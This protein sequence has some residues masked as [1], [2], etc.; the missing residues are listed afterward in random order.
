MI[1]QTVNESEFIQCL[2][3]DEYA[4]WSYNGAQALF[5]YLE[6]LSED[7]GEDIEL[8]RVA[9]R[10]DYSQYSSAWEAM[11]QYQP[12][13]MPTVDDEP[14]ENGVGLDLVELGAAQ[15]QAAFEWLEKR[16]TV[17]QFEGGVIIAQF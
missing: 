12:E 1:K 14:D 8:D 3:S 4:N 13:D 2:L 9:L 10:C 11:D 7:I 16:T 17:I 5:E 6:Q 15:G